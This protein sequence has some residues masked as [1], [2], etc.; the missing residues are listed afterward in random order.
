VRVKRLLEERRLKI[1]Y[2]PAI[3]AALG[4]IKRC[5]TPAGTVRFDA[6]RSEAGHADHFWALA[7]ALHAAERPALSTEF[8]SSGV[9]RAFAQCHAY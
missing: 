6:E 5:I 4:A 3:R 1:P 7:L 2:D 9:A 8:R